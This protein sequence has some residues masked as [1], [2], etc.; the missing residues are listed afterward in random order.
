MSQV[1]GISGKALVDPDV[2]PGSAGH[3]VAEPHMA[4]LMGHQAKPET[5][6][7]RHRLVLHAAAQLCQAVSVFLIYKWIQPI[8]IG[9]QLHHGNRLVY[10]RFGIGQAVGMVVNVIL[11]EDRIVGPRRVGINVVF[12]VIGHRKRDEVIS[13]R[14]I[15]FPFITDFPVRHIGNTG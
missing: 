10:P 12:L 3:L 14:I 15:T 5:T 7:G 11:N 1:I 6:H 9:K 4:E 13:D 2:A 8:E